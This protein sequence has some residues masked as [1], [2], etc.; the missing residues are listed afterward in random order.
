MNRYRN[1]SGGRQA[2]WIAAGFLVGTAAGLL[3]WSWQLRNCGR[4]LFSTS[5]LRRYA[6]LGYLRGQPS[7]ETTRLLRDYVAWE[8]RPALRRRAQRLLRRMELHLD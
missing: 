5:P 3:T 7:V 1:G 4:N 8:Q 2:R 6:A